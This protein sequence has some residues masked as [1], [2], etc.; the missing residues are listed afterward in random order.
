[1]PDGGCGAGEVAAFVRRAR[2][3]RRLAVCDG[4]SEGWGQAG[5]AEV[6]AA[7]RERGVEV[8][9]FEREQVAV[10]WCH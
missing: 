1:M 9:W 6:E 8:E 10:P 7:A 5:R 2:A 4:T 3:L